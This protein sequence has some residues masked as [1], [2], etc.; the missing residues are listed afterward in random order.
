LLLSGVDTTSESGALKELDPRD[1]GFRRDAAEHLSYRGLNEDYGVLDTRGDLDLIAARVVEQI[2]ESSPPTFLLGHSQA[3]LIVDRVLARD[4][5]LLDAAAVL[6]GP[7]RSP[8]HLAIPEPGRSGIGKPGGDVA[9]AISWLVGAGTEQAFDVDAPGTPL[10]QRMVQSSATERRL[11]VWPLL[12]SVWLDQD[13]RRSGEINVV[14]FTDH[15]GVVNNGRAVSQVQ[16]FFAGKPL[17]GDESSFA[18]F[19]SAVLRYTFEPW[20]PRL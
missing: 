13:W 4:P 6:S 8:P 16:S 19:L 15:V 7:P 18:G 20:R 5:Q 11:A 9:R 17:S 1:I 2:E 14:A 12:D 10:K 3:A